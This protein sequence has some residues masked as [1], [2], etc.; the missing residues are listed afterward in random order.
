[1]LIKSSNITY[2]YYFFLLFI[3]IYLVKSNESD[4]PGNLTDFS[5]CKVSHLGLDYIGHIAQTESRVRCQSWTATKPVHKVDESFVDKM[6]SDFSMKRSKN[7]CR[8]PDH[9]AFGPWCYTMESNLI[10][11]TCAIPLCSFTEC[12]ITGPG[13]EYGGSHKHGV[14]GI[15]ILFLKDIFYLFVALRLGISIE[16]HDSSLLLA[17]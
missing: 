5:I 11:E 16:V 9:H 7:Y 13:I 8:N 17:D 4:T 2:I 6:F 12:R 14:S 1:M 15:P 10:N 3:Q